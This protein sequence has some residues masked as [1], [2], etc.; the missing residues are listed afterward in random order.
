MA[1]HRSNQKPKAKVET[2]PGQKPPEQLAPKKNLTIDFRCS[3]GFRPWLR[4][5]NLSLAFSTYEAGKV[6]LV[7]LNEDGT[8]SVFDRRFDRAMGLWA[9]GERMILATTYQLVVFHNLLPPGG[10][11]EGYDRLYAPRVSY[12]TGNLD[13]HDVVEESGGRIV[14]ANTL[15]S[16]LATI[17]AHYCF[18]PLWIPASSP[19]LQAEDHCHLNGLAEVNGAV[20]YISFVG[21]STSREGWRGARVG[22]GQIV[23][24]LQQEVVCDGL[25]MPHSPRFHRGR[26]WVLNSAEG[27]F[28]Y[29]DMATRKFVPTT[30][31]PGYA[32]GLAFVDR[33]A[34]IGLSMPRER[35][36]ALNELP[37]Q[38]NFKTRNVQPHC[39]VII[40][41]I[42]TGEIAHRM[43]LEGEINEFYDVCVLP[44]VRKPK[45]LNFDASEINMYLSH[46]GK[47][48]GVDPAD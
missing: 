11:H 13:V 1:K 14:F 21:S 20:R 17:D 24:V 32:R 30:F 42:E 35:S 25:S 22:G 38:T 19:E 6:F 2:R 46:A 4:Q 8:L 12:V 31:C 3:T 48:Q 5:M 44:G 47:E 18:K 34:L 37:L 27:D 16:C 9:N 28:G 36:K 7:G 43:Y 15:F 10:T 23:D 39:G 26:L 29:V 41:D 45:M 40:V 33:F